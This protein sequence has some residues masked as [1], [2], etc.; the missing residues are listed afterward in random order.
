M[1]LFLPALG[2]RRFRLRRRQGFTLAEILIALTIFTLL[3]AGVLATNLFG[4]RMFQVNQTK[5]KATEWSRRTFGKIADEVRSGNSVVLLNGDTNGNFS[6]VLPGEIQ[7]GNAL[8]IY[9]TKS[10]NSYVIYFVNVTD[11]TFRRTDYPSGNTV[12]LA[13]SV[14]N[15]LPFTAQDFTG[16]R[17][18][19]TLNNQVIHLRLDFYQPQRFLRD[20]DYYKLETSVTRRS[21]P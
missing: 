15:T 21:L 10:T 14:T 5:L 1:K 17:L 9:P 18:T 7:T 11:Q 16:G 2:S 8:Q 3:V 12:I 13:D 6:G 20:P 4:L 19:N